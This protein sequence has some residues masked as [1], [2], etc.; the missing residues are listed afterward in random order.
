MVG[1]VPSTPP[2]HQVIVPKRY[3]I[4]IPHA[5]RDMAMS[6]L[7]YFKSNPFSLSNTFSDIYFGK[8]GFKK[9]SSQ[10]KIISPHL[11][12]WHPS[13]WSSSSGGVSL[14]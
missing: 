8:E 14:V 11:D 6:G 5:K 4:C 12:Y 2:I 10:K 1:G 13:Q 3:T 9:N 7:L